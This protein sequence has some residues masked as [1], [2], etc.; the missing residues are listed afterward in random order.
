[1]AFWQKAGIDS[2]FA[3]EQRLWIDHMLDRVTDLLRPR[4]G[5]RPGLRE[6]AQRLIALVQGISLQLLFDN[7]SWT[8]AGIREVLDEEIR[9][10]PTRDVGSG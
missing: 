4:C 5:D 1:M 3:R 7:R 8:E 9:R 10:L 6:S 2:D